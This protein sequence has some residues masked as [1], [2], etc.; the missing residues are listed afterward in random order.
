MCQG[1]QDWLSHPDTSS[2]LHMDGSGP[3]IVW[4]LSFSV[5]RKFL[6][7]NQ[8]RKMIFLLPVYRVLRF[9]AM[10]AI[11]LVLCSCSTHC[12]SSPG[13]CIMGS[14][15]STHFLYQDGFPCTSSCCSVDTVAN[16]IDKW[17]FSSLCGLWVSQWEPRF[18]HRRGVGSLFLDAR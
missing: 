16:S 7:D 9:P 10:C 18:R 8:E 17:P 2:L 5:P 13:F 14:F 12:L 6:I 15:P 3:L 4:G 1:S 11:S